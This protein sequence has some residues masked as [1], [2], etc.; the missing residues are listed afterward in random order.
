M[1]PLRQLRSVRWLVKF[2][3][4]FLLAP[5]SWAQH[6]EPSLVDRLL[7]P[8]MELQNNAQGKKFIAASSA[9]IEQGGSVGTFYLQPT[10]SEKSFADTR[11]YATSGYTSRSFDSGARAISAPQN[12]NANRQSGIGSSSARNIR[13]VYDAQNAV[14]S[15]DYAEQ[16]QFTEKGKSQKSLDRKNP[17][18]T[19]DQVR[20]LLN[21][22]K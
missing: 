8:N 2:S 17:P 19:V 7:R 22:N 10:R 5:A 6:Q 16:R 18:L 20:E 14:S 1:H 3:L 4:V 9:P 21:K 12:A 15:R 13:P 11:A